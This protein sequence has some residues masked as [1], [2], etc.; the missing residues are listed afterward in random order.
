MA[1]SSLGGG[2]SAIGEAVSGDPTGAPLQASQNIEGATEVTPQLHEL[3]D[4][5]SVGK[6]NHG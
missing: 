6:S 1:G 2:G 4:S 5:S 3:A